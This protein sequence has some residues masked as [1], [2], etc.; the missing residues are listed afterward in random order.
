[1][2]ETVIAS[3]NEKLHKLEKV[4]NAAEDLLRKVLGEQS[5]PA[6]YHT[7]A[8]IEEYLSILQA[9]NQVH[10][11]AFI[12]SDHRYK[13]AKHLFDLTVE[14]SK[15]RK[16]WFEQVQTLTQ[17]HSVLAA[18]SNATDPEFLKKESR[19]NLD[20]IVKDNA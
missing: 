3:L 5:L 17:A 19:L 10:V 2:L 20:T 11:Q 8:S 7:L 12:R 4:N 1:M 6:A 15:C 13:Q 18:L 16:I 9:G 14:Y